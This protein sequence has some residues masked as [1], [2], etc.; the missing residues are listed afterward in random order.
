MSEKTFMK[1]HLSTA[2]RYSYVRMALNYYTY[3]EMVSD[4]AGLNDTFHGLNCEFTRILD[5]FY[6]KCENF[7]ELKVLRS[8]IMHQ[9]E[10]LASYADAFQ[11]YEYVINR[12]E[13]KFIK[14]KPVNISEETIT[15]RLMEFITDSDDVVLMNGKIQ[16]IIGELPVRFTKKRFFSILRQ[17][18]SPYEGSSKKSISDMMYVLKTESMLQFPDD[19]KDGYEDIYKILEHFKSIN[20]KLIDSDEYDNAVK[21]IEYTSDI[22]TRYGNLYQMLQCLINDLCVLVITKNYMV[23]D[24]AEID[25]LEFIVKNIL[26]R[27]QSGEYMEADED[28]IISRMVSLEGRQ[29]QL[30]EK[31][32]RYKPQNNDKETVMTD[33]LL[34]GS[35]FVSLD[36][37]EDDAD[38]TVSKEELAIAIEK[39]EEE[40]TAGFAVM[41]KPVIRAVMAKIL[42]RLPVYFS[43]ANEVEE[44]ILNSLLSCT[45]DNEKETSIELLQMLVE[46]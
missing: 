29:E 24:T 38:K 6:N 35:L 32:I 44:Y 2:Y 37:E 40:L 20:Y 8:N 27:F 9:M 30:F 10:I 46:M 39:L 22:L 25:N 12:M 43:S 33:R 19:M 42:S 15:E 41:Q 26:N 45:D 34:S 5:A 28:D 3:Y 31:Y 11:L 13:R 4:E 21:D 7:D 1:K 36:E 18:L 14:K 23:A 16:D 17:G